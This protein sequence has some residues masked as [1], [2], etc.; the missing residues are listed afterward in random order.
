MS[1]PKGSENKKPKQDRTQYTTTFNVINNPCMKPIWDDGE[2]HYTGDDYTNR[3]IV[4]WEETEYTGMTPEQTIQTMSEKWVEEDKE[5]RT[6][7]F[8]YCIKWYDKCGDIDN[9]LQHVH[10]VL[11]SKKPYRMTDIKKIFPG[12]HVSPTKG[13]KK[14]AMDYINK[15]GKY[16]EKAEKETVVSTFS[17]G[18]VFGAERS[19]NDL[20][21]IE[22]FLRDG[23]TPQEIYAISFGFRRYSNM[24]EKAYL[25]DKIKNC[26]P[27]LEQD[28]WWHCGES[29]TGKSHTYVDLC[30]E[31]GKE[32]IY[33]IPAGCDMN[34]AFDN[35][36]GQPIVFIDELRPKTFKFDY[37]LQILDEYTGEIR[38]RYYNKYKL[39]TEV[40]VTTVYAPEEF[41]LNAFSEGITEEFTDTYEQLRR[42]IK[43]CVMHHKGQSPRS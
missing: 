16:A 3:E 37:L 32:N 4:G 34:N 41:Y 23:L 42:R 17:I 7:A 18:E 15:T 28:V 20:K 19:K 6:C 9:C 21:A 8:A 10:C 22:G 12:I 39:W 2:A 33:R 29:G 38:A 24:I 43:H 40:H 36:A 11:C 35:Y 30:E 13:T 25:D 1:R 26:P 27:I 14:E 31:H 5:N